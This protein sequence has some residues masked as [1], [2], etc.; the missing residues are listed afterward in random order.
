MNNKSQNRDLE[1]N[2]ESIE[3]RIRAGQSLDDIA[4]VQLQGAAEALQLIERVRS[5]QASDTLLDRETV[6]GTDTEVVLKEIPEQIGRFEIKKTNRP[7]RFW[8]RFPRKRSESESG[9]RHQSP[10]AH[11]PFAH[12]NCAKIFARR[13]CGS[14]LGSSQH[15]AGV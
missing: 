6:A 8:C 1:K 5:Q 10:A 12:Q 3:Q 2:L 13:S 11:K 14:C 15:R 4:D 9:G 7:R